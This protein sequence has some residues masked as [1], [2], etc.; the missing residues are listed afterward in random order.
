MSKM[1][2]VSV[3]KK[4]IKD[5]PE[6]IKR[7]ARV[8]PHMMQFETNEK[9]WVGLEKRLIMVRELMNEKGLVQ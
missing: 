5:K 2:S 1:V 8:L 4:N 6:S 7:L 3:L 9:V